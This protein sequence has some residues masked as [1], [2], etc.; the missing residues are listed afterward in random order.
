MDSMY[1]FLC[2][3]KL[4]G[5]NV[6]RRLVVCTEGN[7]RTDNHL[8]HLLVISCIFPPVLMCDSLN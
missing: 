8:V 1:D 2:M 3:V 7:Q 5:L 4:E 6:V